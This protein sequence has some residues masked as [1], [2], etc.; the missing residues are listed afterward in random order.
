M[1]LLD[2]SFNAI[3]DA[4]DAQR[5]HPVEV[6]SAL[7]DAV[8]AVVGSSA[9]V[10]ELGVG[11][12][13]IALP[14]MAA[15]GWV[16]G[17]DLATAMLQ[18]ARVRTRMV[19]GWG[20]I[21]GDLKLVQGDVLQ[22]PF[23]AGVFDAALAVHVLHL[24][25]DWRAGLT[26]VTR[27]LRPGGCLIQG[28]DWRDPESCSGRLRSQLRQIVLELAPGLRPPAAGAAFTRGLERLGG[29]SETPFVAARWYQPISPAATL[30][31][32]A[33]RHDT[34]TWILPADLL[35]AA[36]VRLN[37]WAEQTWFDLDQEE[38]V[39]HQFV[40]TVT[41][42]PKPPVRRLPGKGTAAS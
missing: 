16:V 19:S 18:A 32:M 17:V 35:A 13:R 41:R 20:V 42:F 30:R 33:A 4:Y 40:M 10:L 26:E 29:V 22:M 12:G 1:A 37:A 14:V 9:R 21:S 11:T 3:A 39:E 36:M 28:R 7:G 34:E 25:A 6:A 38:Q 8:T 31:A 27:V 23:A 5:A 15:G 2:F 24:L